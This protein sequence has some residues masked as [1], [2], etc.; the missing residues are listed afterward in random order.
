MKWVI[1][2]NFSGYQVNGPNF[3]VVTDNPLTYILTSAKFNATGLRW[4]AELA[5]YRFQYC[6]RAG[7]KHID[8]DYLFRHKTDDF[9]KLRNS[10]DKKVGV[11]DDEC[12]HE[13]EVG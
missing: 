6:Y 3:E 9:E 5:N 8:A 2:K 1:S 13:E 7:R 10:A 11:E 4:V 12:L